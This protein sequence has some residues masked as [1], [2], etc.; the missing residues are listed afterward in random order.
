MS[1]SQTTALFDP[2]STEK[3]SLGTLGYVRARS[4]QGAY[5]LVIREFK[6]SGITQADLARRIGKAAEVVSRLL[7]R[8]SNWELDTF[9][10][11]MFGICGAVPKYDGQSPV[12]QTKISSPIPAKIDPELP[13]TRSERL[14][15]ITTVA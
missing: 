6:K 13:P 9:T 3:I 1:T 2:T 12:A 14:P 7:G 15:E 8:P 10:D 4:R 11:L 5:N